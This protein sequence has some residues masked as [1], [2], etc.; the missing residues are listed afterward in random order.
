MDRN[1]FSQ[2]SV[3]NYSSAIRLPTTTVLPNRT[4]PRL[5]HFIKTRLAV[6][7]PN[8]LLLV[9]KNVYRMIFGQFT[10]FCRPFFASVRSNLLITKWYL[11]FL[12]SIQHADLKLNQERQTKKT[13]KKMNQC[14]IFN[15]PRVYLN[16]TRLVRTSVIL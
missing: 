3:H 10:R 1:Y 4:C 16:V 12:R 8:R 5:R 2:T 7:Y 9:T 13:K 11:T 14:F 15:T 6:P